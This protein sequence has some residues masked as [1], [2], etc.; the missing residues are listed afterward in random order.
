[1]LPFV[2]FYSMI[3]I[4]IAK[5]GSILARIPHDD[6]I[7]MGGNCAGLQDQGEQHLCLQLFRFPIMAFSLSVFT[8]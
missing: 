8:G 3:V 6:Y 5:C 4:F 7:L 2:I 1:M